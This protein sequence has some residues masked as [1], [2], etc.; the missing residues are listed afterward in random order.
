MA[1]FNYDPNQHKEAQSF[2]ALPAGWYP[3]IISD[4][5][6]VQTSKKDGFRLVL[7]FTIIDGPHKGRKI[8]S[9]YNIDNPSAKAVE[10]SMSELKSICSVIG[11]FS[12]IADSQELHNQPLQIRLVAPKDSDY[13]EVKGYKDIAGN[14]PGKSQQVAPVGHQ[15]QPAQGFGNAPHG[16]V[17]DRKSVV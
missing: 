7:T 17:A 3:A 13:N 6:I 9:G 14:D 5:E 11:K 10:I 8:N 12:P 16:F 15:Q 2:E 1:N 4:S